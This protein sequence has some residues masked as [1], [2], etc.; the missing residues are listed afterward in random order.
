MP[1]A[2]EWIKELEIEESEANEVA[3]LAAISKEAQW[4][5]DKAREYE[6][7]KFEFFGTIPQRMR[8]A[9][10]GWLSRTDREIVQ[11][12]DT[13]DYLSYLFNYAGKVIEITLLTDG[14]TE[15]RWR[16]A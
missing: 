12:T 1:A 14:R 13:R 10:H 3:E 9:L 16:A 4:M 7:G 5:M 15:L 8:K 11:F 6:A 2:A